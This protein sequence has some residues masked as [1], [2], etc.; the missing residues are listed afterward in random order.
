VY[1]PLHLGDLTYRDRII[2]SL[3]DLERLYWLHTF[4]SLLLPEAENPL[5]ANAIVIADL[6]PY[7]CLPQKISG[8]PDP[9]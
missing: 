1:G 5:S 3:F 4:F 8:L 6:S 2:G 9:L 7:S